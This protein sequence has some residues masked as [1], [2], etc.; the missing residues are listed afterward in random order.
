MLNHIVSESTIS[1]PWHDLPSC[2]RLVPH[3]PLSAPLFW[4][5]LHRGPARLAVDHAALL[6]AP[7]FGDVHDVLEAALRDSDLRDAAVSPRRIALLAVVDDLRDLLH[8]GFARVLDGLPVCLGLP[9]SG[10]HVRWYPTCRRLVLLVA[11]VRDLRLRQVG[12]FSR[13][14]RLSVMSSK[15][16]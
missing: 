14:T 8:H 16:S 4:A 6:L 2:R 5:L 3:L 10:D 1:V 13:R 7:Y 11:L 12:L 15:A 9:S